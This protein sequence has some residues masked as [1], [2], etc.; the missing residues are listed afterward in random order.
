L[1]LDL[2]L[3]LFYFYF[4]SVSNIGGLLGVFVG[5]SLISFIEVIEILIAALFVKR[6]KDC[7]DRDKVDPLH[8]VE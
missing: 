7:S 3:I 6:K 8:L 2:I 4:I 5:Y 1:N